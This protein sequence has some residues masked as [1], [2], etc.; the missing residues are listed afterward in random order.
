MAIID[1]CTRK[2]VGVHVSRRGRALE[3]E[4][5]LKMSC[6]DEL[7]L[8]YSKGEVRPVP[9]SD[10][11]K[12]FISK[13]FTQRCSQ[14]GLNQEFI[15]PYT[16]QQNGMIER[17]FRS[18]KEECIWL[19]NFQGLKDAKETISEWVTFYNKEQP[20]QMLRYLITA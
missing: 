9:R 11:E 6:L 19:R 5:A 7:G 2:I 3:A 13:R 1:C 4:K 20:H 15:T 17:F 12:V 10:N 14:Y 18:L 8:V 16:P